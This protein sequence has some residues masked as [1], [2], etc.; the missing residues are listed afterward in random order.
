[1]FVDP[2]GKLQFCHNQSGTGT[3][4]P[5]DQVWTQSG[6]NIYPAD[7]A[8]D[9]DVGI[10][11]MSPAYALYVNGDIGVTPR[12]R[13]FARYSNDETY[14][15]SLDWNS[16]QLGNNGT[17]Y[18][19]AG[20][21]QSG[22]SLQFVTNNTNDYKYDGVMMPNGTTVMTL[23]A[24]GTVAVTGTI[25]APAFNGGPFGIFSSGPIGAQ[26][27][28]TSNATIIGQS[29]VISPGPKQFVI[30]HPLKPGYQLAHAS[31]EGPEA[32][33]Y[34]R[35]TARLSS[36]KAKVTLPDYFDALTRDGEATILLTAKGSEPFL[37][38]YDHFDEKS[39][40]VHGTKPDGEF[41][42]EV[43]SVRGDLSPL[44]VEPKK[45]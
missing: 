12:N 42:W 29:L 5:I 39:F 35:G 30:D 37:L 24:D 7:I 17:N 40:V 16:L 43:K 8:S 23:R 21:T 2:N 19:I 34:Y 6:N 13:F 38:S 18:I 28:L 4:G 9:P 14:K 32:G 31:L 25:S 41:D 20:R 10:G 36:G 27:N 11:T 15:A 22:G 3:W 33:V 45:D 26:G 44:E 1:M